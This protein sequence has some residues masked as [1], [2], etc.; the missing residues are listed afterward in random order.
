MVI[1][2]A[3]KLRLTI[4]NII[5]EPVTYCYNGSALQSVSDDDTNLW[6]RL[7][8]YE[9]NTVMLNFS[10]VALPE[11]KRHKGIFTKVVKQLLALSFVRGI[12]ITSVC[13]EEMHNF[14]VSRGFVTDNGFDFYKVK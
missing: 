7:R 2:N 4:E 5:K 14:C 6:I 12:Y 11:N 1:N 3:E 9:D 13:T 10:S 8:W